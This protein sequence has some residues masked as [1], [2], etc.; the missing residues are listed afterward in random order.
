MGL[1]QWTHMFPP[2]LNSL[3][4]GPAVPNFEPALQ[5]CG[6]TGLDRRAARSQGEGTVAVPSGT[7]VVKGGSA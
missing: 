1:A 6:C 4:T 2:V 5:R 3:H 7:V